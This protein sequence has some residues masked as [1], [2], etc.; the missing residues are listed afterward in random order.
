MAWHLGYPLSQTLFT[1]VYVE[2][3]LVPPPMTV[4]DAD[5]VRNRSPESQSDPLVAVLRAYCLGMLKVCWYVIEQ[6]KSEH[7]YEVM[8]QH[9]HYDRHRTKPSRRLGRRLCHK[10][11]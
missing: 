2:A 6:I 9:R 5:F 8:S 11:L 7:Y 4:E 3:I 10:H 1:N